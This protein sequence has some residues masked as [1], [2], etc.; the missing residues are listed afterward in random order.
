MAAVIDT[1]RIAAFVSV[2]ESAILTLL[3]NPTS[4]LVRNLLTSLTP[5][6]QEHEELKSQKLKQDIELETAIRSS[7][8]KAK[9]LKTNVE[10]GLA[11]VG[12]LRTELQQSG[13]YSSVQ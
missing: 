1:R 10:K 5:K 9:V 2:S 8:S 7:E 4:E 3:D 6:I 13:E 12:K 11:E